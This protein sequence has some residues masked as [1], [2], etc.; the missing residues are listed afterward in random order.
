ME[1]PVQYKRQ[2]LQVTDTAARCQ[3]AN[4]GEEGMEQ[5]N[6]R[7]TNAHS[8]WWCPSHLGTWTEGVC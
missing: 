5:F 1:A 2:G 4:N 8:V 3:Q 7:D 6:H